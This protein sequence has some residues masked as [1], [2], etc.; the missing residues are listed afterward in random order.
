MKT[1]IIVML[2]CSV[3]VVA[4]AQVAPKPDLPASAAKAFKPI[5]EDRSKCVNKV[6]FA[7]WLEA[8]KS[9]A[10]TQGI[11][12]ETLRLA[13]DQFQVDPKVV[14]KDRAQFKSKSVFGQTF[15]TFS[16][17]MATDGRRDKAIQ[18][19]KKHAKTFSEIE[20]KYGVPAAPLL[21]FWA[22]ES[23]FGASTGTF[24]ILR[25]A[26]TLAYDC[27]RHEMFREQAF[28]ALKLVE[29]KHIKPDAVGNWAG[30]L[31]GLQFMAKDYLESGVD[32]DGDGRI[33]IVGSI[34]DALATAGQFLKS[35]GWK[36]GQAWMREVI[37]PEVMRWEEATMEIKKPVSAWAALGVKP[38]QG[39]FVNE[40]NLPASLLL[41]M[42]RLGPA[43]LAY[44]NLDALLGWNESL[45]YSTT[46]AFLA[47]RIVGAKPMQRGSANLKTLALG[48]VMEL[49]KLL[50]SN[51]YEPGEPD[52][53]I[54]TGTR[55]AVRAAQL[56]LGLP[57]DG[58]PSEELLLKMRNK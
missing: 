30:E 19:A 38:A 53:K 57:A 9:E 31:G 29:K 42:G 27:R 14:E 44:P 13:N 25:S 36:K 20:A 52:G 4:S 2:F 6:P 54:G 43:F 8:F 24:Q 22:L 15:L 45:V 47:T 1:N 34:P 39:E 23:D 48:E 50:K 12:E 28:S 37:V 55:S 32:H 21:S 11:S 58:Y 40:L 46:A 26:V 56:K 41:P 33:D 10:L 49:Q 17:R 35:K 7:K 3:Q 5:P 51:G 16:D 18:L